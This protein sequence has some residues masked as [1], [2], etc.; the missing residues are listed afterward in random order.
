MEHPLE[1]QIS[2]IKNVIMYSRVSPYWQDELSFEVQE[3]RMFAFADM[4]GLSVIGAARETAAGSLEPYSRPV[5]QQALQ[6]CKNQ[7]RCVLLVSDVDRLT[8]YAALVYELN[9]D[10]TI[11]F[12]SA[13]H[14][15]RA[16]HLHVSMSA[17]LAQENNRVR[18]EFEGIDVVRVSEEGRKRFAQNKKPMI[19]NLLKYGLTM[20]EVVTNMENIRM[21]TL[22]GFWSVDVIENILKIG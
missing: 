6:D 2:K 1:K 19:E 3:E 20:E 12:I 9:T 16:D 8:E 21:E 7:K 11:R 10:K 5:L 22:D 14:G 18:C 17:I 13:K 15:M 4:N